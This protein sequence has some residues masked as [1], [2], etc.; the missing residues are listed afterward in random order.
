MTDFVDRRQ[1]VRLHDDD[2][3]AID[4]IITLLDDPQI[5]LRGTVKRQGE[6]LYGNGKLGLTTKFIILEIA[7]FL[8]A[9]VVGADHPVILKLLNKF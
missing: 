3:Q 8:V 4:R 6:T 9:C 1:P 7:L 2:R 5:G